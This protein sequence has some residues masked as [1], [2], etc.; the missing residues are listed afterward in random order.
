M[1]FHHLSLF[2]SNTKLFNHKR[3]KI[4]AL[5]L[6]IIF[7]VYTA[8]FI[9]AL[10]FFP[11]SFFIKIQQNFIVIEAII[12]EYTFPPFFNFFSLLIIIITTITV[13]VVIIITIISII[14]IIGLQMELFY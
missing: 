5:L 7:A 2:L 13:T 1:H 11:L 9:N 8:S 4:K 3:I 10:N 12:M 6:V 14:V